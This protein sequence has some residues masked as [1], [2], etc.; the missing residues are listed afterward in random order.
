MVDLGDLGKPPDPIEQVV[1]VLD[2]A[3]GKMGDRLEPMSS[4]GACGFKLTGGIGRIDE[5]DKNLRAAVQSG[6][7][8][9]N[10]V[11]LPRGDLKG[12][13]GQE[14]SDRIGHKG[15]FEAAVVLLPPCAGRGVGSAQNCDKRSTDTTLGLA[16]MSFLVSEM[17]LMRY[18]GHP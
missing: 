6:G 3:G 9:G 10:L 8:E 16:K 13:V 17:A 4:D 12:E 11:A 18:F 1:P 2:E 15:W 5:G 14:L 7:N